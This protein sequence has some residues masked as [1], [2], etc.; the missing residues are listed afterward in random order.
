M[1]LL[2]MK[3]N[4]KL[5]FKNKSKLFLLLAVLYFIF[6]LDF[7]PDILPGIGWGDD[8]LILLASLLMHYKDHLVKVKK[9]EKTVEG[10]IID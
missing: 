7:I 1:D 3:R 8:L 10:E 9:E 5:Q 4:K 6:P 2:K